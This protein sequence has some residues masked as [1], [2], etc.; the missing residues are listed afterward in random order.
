MQPLLDIHQDIPSNKFYPPRLETS[1]SLFRSRLITETLGKTALS[2][3]IIVLEAQAG[4][5]KSILAAQF[6]DHY[7]LRFAWY[8]I[9]PEDTDPVL[10]L[11]ALMA[12]FSRRLPGFESRQLSRIMCQGEI[13]PLDL[14]RCINIL[15]ADLDTFL[16]GDF[17][18]VFDDMHLVENASL[19]RTLLDHL[20]DTAPPQL[21]FLLISRR[22]LTLAANS[23][24][25][26]SDTLY[27][28]ND[29]LC[30]S[31]EEV[32]QLF[33]EVL[34][35]NISHSEARTLLE[36]TA[37]WIMGILLAVHP[38]AGK[39]R[40]RPVLPGRLSAPQ[41]LEYFRDEIFAQIPKKMQ[42]PLLRLSQLDEIAVELA[43]QIT[44][45]KDIGSRLADMMQDNFFVYPL[46]DELRIFRFHH[47]F[48]E[49]LQHRAATTLSPAEIEQINETAARYYLDRG[50]LEKAM[51]CFA[52]Q[53]NYRQMEEL[54]KQEGMELL[55]RNRTVTLLTLLTSIP[56]EKLLEHGWLTLFCGLVHADFHPQKT[57]PMLEAARNRFIILGEET[58]ELLALSQIIY[59][60]FVVSGLYHTGA[61]LLPRTEELF[62]KLRDELPVNARIMVARNLAAGYCFFNS[63]MEQAR[64]YGRMAR[65]LSIQHDIRNCIAST[66]FVCGY[67]ETLVGNPKGCLQEIELSSPLLHD[68]LVGMSNKLTLR[69]LQLNYLT[70]YGDVINFDHQQE[71][72]RRSIDSHV[73]EQTVAAPYL[74]VW[75]CACLVSVG[76]FDRAREMLL[77]GSAVSESAKIPHMKSQ[78]LQWQGYLHALA[79]NREETIRAL[80]EA[81]ELR[82]QSGGPFYETMYEIIAGASL[83]RVGMTERA[84]IH[85]GN[86]L[87]GAG[88][89][90]SPYLEAAVLLHRAFLHLGE[91]NDAGAADDL[92]TGLRLMEDNGYRSFWSW[93][94]RFM[95]TLLDVAVRRGIRAKFADLLARERLGVFLQK[96]EEPVPLLLVRILGPWRIVERERT[97]LE[98]ADFTPAQR[99]LLSLLLTAPGQK[100]EQEAVQAVLWPDSSPE[101]ARAKFDTLLVRLRKVLAAAVQAPVRHYLVLRKGILRL[102]NCRI[103]ALEFEQLARSGIR[104]AHAER[105]WQAANAFHRAVILWDGPL[106]SDGAT[107]GQTTEFYDRLV[108]LLTRMTDTW[109]VILAESDCIDQA[110]EL[111]ART[112][113]YD[114]MNDRLI[115]LLYGL[116]LRAGNPLKAKETIINYRQVLRDMDYD[117]DQIDD[118]LFQVASKGMKGM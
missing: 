98:A 29:D 107:A 40:Q 87:A 96:K 8:Q 50:A 18:L 23:L 31:L 13:G 99:T 47:L 62:L 2:A 86:G 9:G 15:L 103:D 22:P 79:G 97:V 109:A 3:K 46:D 63:Q 24:R 71:L 72:L 49:F 41:L 38:L 32:E 1:G 34:K 55:A 104:H 112:L 27:L 85:L 118:L 108:A 70:K 28:D 21:H 39:R 16:A 52:A 106:E 17:Y 75:G 110:I 100:V 25:F 94:P 74:Y 90:D 14:K 105:Y 101:K 36:S 10:L 44:G 37:G 89:I 83:G 114:P 117:Q 76:R 43:E 64:H 73:V 82:R 113:R 12:N 45:R 26:G 57:L 11:S 81:G 95:T 88:N 115:S 102:R 61:L 67:I 6:L 30:L 56:E 5:G 48:Q 116:Y 92:N 51:A 65:D 19:T 35:I 84:R 78:I 33:T 60:H 54:L 80:E 53:G 66:R 69:V 4:Q 20:I 68:P 58:G 91:G 42:Q 7:D 59:F 111:L 77:Q 93:E